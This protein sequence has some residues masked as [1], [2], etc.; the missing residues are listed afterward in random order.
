MTKIKNDIVKSTVVT[1]CLKA[2]KV[3]KLTR[4]TNSSIPHINDCSYRVC[5][6]H[7]LQTLC[8]SC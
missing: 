4:W 6:I 8:R 5:S 2:C 3:T 7:V 1:V